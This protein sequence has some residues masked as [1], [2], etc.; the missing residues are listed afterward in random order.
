MSGLTRDETTE[1]VSRD[2]ILRRERGQ[3]RAT[4]PVQLITGR[5]G[6]HIRLMPSLLKVM[7]QQ[8][9]L[10][11]FNTVALKIKKKRPGKKIF[12]RLHPYA[13]LIRTT[14]AALFG[15]STASS[16]TLRSTWLGCPLGSLGIEPTNRAY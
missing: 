7:N 12:F 14:R 15:Q 1:P 3:G 13:L 8:Q 11:K 4:S 2:Q 16:T 5:I 10:G 9:Q 6:N